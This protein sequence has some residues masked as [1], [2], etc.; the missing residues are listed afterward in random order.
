[1]GQGGSTF[2]DAELEE[3]ETLTFLSRKEILR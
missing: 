3:Y 1:M 2:T